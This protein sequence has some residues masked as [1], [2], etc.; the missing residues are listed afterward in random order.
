MTDERCPSCGWDKSYRYCL[1]HFHDDF[2][3]PVIN[4]LNEVTKML[5]RNPFS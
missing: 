1:D 4:A 5:K 3:H 2:V